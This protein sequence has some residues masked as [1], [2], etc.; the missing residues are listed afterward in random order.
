MNEQLGKT[1]RATCTVL[2]EDTLSEVDDTG[3]DDEAPR[4]VSEAV[5][6]RVVREAASVVRVDRVANEA[7]GSVR[8]KSDEEEERKVM[9]VPEGL[10]ALVA[11]LAVRRRVHEEHDEEHEVA[12]DTTWLR[13]VDVECSLLTDLSTLDVDEVDVVRGGVDACPESHGVGDL[14]VEP[15]VLVRGEEGCHTRTD[16]A[17]D[18]AKLENRAW[19]VDSE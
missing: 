4:L 13:V 14:P 7:A 17:D 16:D 3:P 5:L 6:G 10:E 15:D 18:V 1:R 12:G 19:S 2:A 11:D 8:V 9:C